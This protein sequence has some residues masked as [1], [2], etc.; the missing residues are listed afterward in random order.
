ME[1]RIEDLEVRIAFQEES[2]HELNK[3][4]L[5]LQQEIDRLN[6]E[7][8]QLKQQLRQAVAT[9]LEVSDAPPPHY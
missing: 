7:L 2:I 9:G 8:A 5:R 1:K 6:Q 4:Q 3:S